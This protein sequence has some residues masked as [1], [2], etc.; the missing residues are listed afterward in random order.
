MNLWTNDPDPGMPDDPGSPP[1]LKIT[2]RGRTTRITGW[3]ALVRLFGPVL[4]LGFALGLLLGVVL[5]VTW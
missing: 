5:G 2:A 3:A 4:L 1:V